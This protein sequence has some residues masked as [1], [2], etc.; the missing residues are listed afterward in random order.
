MPIAPTGKMKRL[1]A[2]WL[3]GTIRIWNESVSADVNETTGQPVA[4]E[5]GV[6]TGPAG[7][8]EQ[9]V[10]RVPA[11]TVVYGSRVLTVKLAADTTGLPATDMRVRFLG[12]AAL[13]DQGAGKFRK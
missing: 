4:T 11:E 7:F 12:R 6:W 1:Q 2:R 13:S 3:T 5:S 10:D 9:S 8:H